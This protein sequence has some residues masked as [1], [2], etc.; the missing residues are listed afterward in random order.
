MSIKRGKAQ[1]T[2]FIIIAVLIVVVVLLAIFLSPQLFKKK[3]TIVDR[4]D[5]EAYISDCIK[6]DFE[7][8]IDL[9]SK[10]GGSLHPE[11]LVS[12]YYQDFFRTNLCFQSIQY[13]TCINQKPLLKESIESELKNELTSGSLGN[14]V[15]SCIKSFSEEATKKGYTVSKCSQSQLQ[16]NVTII[17][18]KVAIPINCPITMNRADDK[19]QFSSFTPSIDSQLYN[20][21]LISQTMILDEQQKGTFDY[22]T[23]D[24]LPVNRGK[25]QVLPPFRINDNIKIYT[26]KDIP[27]GKEFVF[28]ISSWS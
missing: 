24:V 8:I 21:I 11:E 1:V 16:F 4:L 20:L 23:F 15:Y 14:I 27:T 9:I 28:S 25:I 13:K 26:I 10:Q 5:P 17:Q 22:K 18:D 19:K 2:I 7:P 3:V 12:V 6:S